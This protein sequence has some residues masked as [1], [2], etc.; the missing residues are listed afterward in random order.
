MPS[1]RVDRFLTITARILV[2]VTGFLWLGLAIS[3]D[4]SF[5]LIVP[6]PWIAGILCG[7]RPFLS[8]AL[9]LA[10]AM[11]VSYL[12]FLAFEN[13]GPYDPRSILPF[14][15][16]LIAPALGATAFMVAIGLVRSTRK[17]P[18]PHVAAAVSG[19]PD[20]RDSNDI[21]ER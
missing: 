4:R 17:T 8:A 21:R 11:V 19:S 10:P 12:A 15:I 7:R 3:V 5:W 13:S 20:R 16:A 2:L 6:L 9:L 1:Y 14:D 18:S